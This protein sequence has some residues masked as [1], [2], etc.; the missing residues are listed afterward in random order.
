MPQVWAEP[1]CLLV[2][3]AQQPPPRS[4][5]FQGSFRAAV[6][7]K[8]M[9]QALQALP[10]NLHQHCN[11]LCHKTLCC[12]AVAACGQLRPFLKA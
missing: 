1:S 2:E 3:V 9:V 4:S 6:L 10:G 7:E 5:R 11:T 8:P 12:Y